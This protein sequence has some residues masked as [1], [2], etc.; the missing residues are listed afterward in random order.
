MA[1]LKDILLNENNMD[2]LEFTTPAGT[3]RFEQLATILLDGDVFAVLHP[4]DEMAGVEDDEA[5][6]YRLKETPEESSLVMEEDEDV[7][8]RVFDMYR[9]L[10]DDAQ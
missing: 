5:I 2:D 10:Q 7:A 8:I 9:S 4:L 3:L 6:V 1:S